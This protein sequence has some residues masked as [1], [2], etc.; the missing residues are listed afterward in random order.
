MYEAYLEQVI[1]VPHVV[2]AQDPSGHL[3][4]PKAHS[5][6]IAHYK[7]DDLQVPSSH[8]IGFSSGQIIYEGQFYIS[9]THDP[10]GHLN[11]VSV[12]HNSCKASA[13]SQFLCND[14]HVPSIHLIYP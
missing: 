9:E 3:F 1:G 7:L 10:S 5:V 14:V 6:L 11:G 4:N 13:Y 8:L 2:K 12:E